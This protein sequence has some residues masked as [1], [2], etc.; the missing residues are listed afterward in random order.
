MDVDCH[1]HIWTPNTK[2][3]PL[4]EGTTNKDLAPPSFTTDELLAVARR[5]G[6]GRVVLIQHHVFY[7]WD[8]SYMIDAAREHPGTFAIVGM[9]DDHSKNPDEQM[10]RLLKQR[11]TG[12][13]ITPRIYGKQK[14]LDGPGMSAMWRCAAETRQNM[15]CLIDPHDLPGVRRMCAKFP[16]TPVV[17]DHF[18]RV[19]VDGKIR[20][21]QVEQLCALAKF[22]NTHLKVS[23]FY[24]LGKRQPPYTELIPMIRRVFEAFGPERLMWG[25]DSPYQLDGENTYEASIDLVRNGLKFLT[26]SDRK[27]LLRDTAN[28]VFFSQLS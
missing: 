20:D 15:C 28:N 12:F 13:R 18:A 8:N 25:S 24:A 19:G 2:K 16:D 6:V 21:E 23:A 5:N 22:K 10:R 14:W 3:Y 9:V 1:S 11:V 7:G 4:K 17:I 27:S 26:D